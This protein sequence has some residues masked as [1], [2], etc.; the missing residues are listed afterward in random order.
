MGY[1]ALY[2]TERGV[3]TLH[4]FCELPSGE[5]YIREHVIIDVIAA[6][7]RRAKFT[8]YAIWWRS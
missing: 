5:V 4:T 8:S 6:L 2:G 3:L 7:L 1:V